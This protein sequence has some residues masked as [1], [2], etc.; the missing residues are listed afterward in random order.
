MNQ[1]GLKFVLEVALK[2]NFDKGIEVNYNHSIGNGIHTT[3]S[4][5]DHFDENDVFA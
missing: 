5:I 1:A 3:I 4:N 2:E